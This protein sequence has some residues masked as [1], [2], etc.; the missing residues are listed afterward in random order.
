[1]V[2]IDGYVDRLDRLLQGQRR[3]RSDLVAE[4]RDGLVDA[5]EALEARGIDRAIAE[6]RAIAEFGSAEEIA[7]AFRS[8]LGLA[9]ARRTLVLFA[10]VLAPQ[11]ILWDEGRWP[12]N[13]GEREF[14]DSQLTLLL[15]G[16]VENL[17]GVMMIGTVIAVVACGIGTRW[18]AARRYAARFTALFVLITWLGI[19]LTGVALTFAGNPAPAG[20]LMWLLL[21]VTGPLGLAVVSAHRCLKIA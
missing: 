1:V 18:P 14:H 11:P 12:W 13:S 9:Q 5:T 10:A 7:E 16:L 20:G 4:V 6:C 15:D 8:E 17:G 3:V 2:S 19:T 21:L